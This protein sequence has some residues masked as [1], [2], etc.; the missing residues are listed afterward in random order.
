[1]CDNAS[2]RSHFG[3][4]SLT[5]ARSVCVCV[6][7]TLSLTASLTILRPILFLD[8]SVSAG[9]GTS[10]ATLISR[11]I[12]ASRTVLIS[13]TILTSRTTPVTTWRV[14]RR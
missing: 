13:R 1:M 14:G 7:K 3:P 10:R 11:A 6:H 2:L 5:T 4:F 9:Y 12:L 8:G